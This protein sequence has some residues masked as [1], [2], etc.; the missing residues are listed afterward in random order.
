MAVGTVNLYNKF[1]E[2]CVLSC[3]IHKSSDS[4]IFFLGIYMLVAQLF[5]SLCKPMDCSRPGSSLQGILQARILEWVALLGL[6]PMEICPCVHQRHVH[7]HHCGWKTATMPINGHWM[8]KIWNSHTWDE[9][10]EWPTTIPIIW[11]E[12]TNLILSKERQ[13]RDRMYDYIYRKS[14]NRQN[15]PMLSETSKVLSWGT[16]QWCSKRVW[17]GPSNWWSCSASWSECYMDASRLWKLIDS[18]TYDLQTFPSVCYTLITFL[19]FDIKHC[20]RNV[21]WCDKNLLVLQIATLYGFDER[22]SVSCSVLSD[23]LWHHGL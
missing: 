6:S 4:A 11:M 7:V 20:Q 17:G 10:S 19:K 1:A 9:C 21:I 23:S 14:K 18:H 2:W 16:V 8:M 22:E 13:Q 3:L 5:S 12:F 15:E